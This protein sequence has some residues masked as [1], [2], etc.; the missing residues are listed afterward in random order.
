MS[1]AARRIVAEL[2]AVGREH[3]AVLLIVAVYLVAGYA[4][5]AFAVP[6]LMRGLWHLPTFQAFLAGGLCS[7]PVLVL[8]RR[9]RLRDADGRR[10]RG[11]A[12]WRGAWTGARAELFTVPRLIRLAFVL[13]LV[14][15]FL[16]A[17]GR[18]K[19]LIQVVQPFAWDARLSALD[20][21]LHLGHLPWTILQPAV[22]SPPVTR[23]LDLI[24]VP[25]LLS[26]LIGMTVWQGWTTD[27]ALRQRFLLTFVL[28]WILLGTGLAIALSSAGP[29][30]FGRVTGLPDPY[31]GLMSYLQH[32]HQVTPLTALAIQEGLW[33]SHVTRVAGTF[34][35]ISAM[36]SIHVAMPTL[37]ALAGGR[38][39]RR[40][41][42]VLGILAV[43][44]FVGSVALG[45][46]Y[47]VDGYV[48]AAGVAL[49][50]V[51]CR[52]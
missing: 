17:F 45:W 43:L 13:F 31:A 9:L 52:R 33:Q 21:A 46:H 23:L 25:V 36:P 32:V 47:A 41:G 49:L 34:S 14:P 1:L 16:G 39:D 50:W 42:W 51:L 20:A 40:L 30:Y 11:A 10:V 48:G 38:A 44:V 2:V 8:A 27:G 5:Q 28:A 26:V 22:G 24:Y 7:A 12:G 19:L 18:W 37:F 15:L 29:C 3:R 6:G 4:I 35:E